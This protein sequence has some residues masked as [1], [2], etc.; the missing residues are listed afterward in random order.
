[1]SSEPVFLH[2]GLPKTGTT[3]LQK[4]LWENRRRLAEN[5]VVYP[6]RAPARW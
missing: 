1:M 6:G 3:E 2:V 5:G 4:V